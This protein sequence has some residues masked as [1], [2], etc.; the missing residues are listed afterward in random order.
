M[1][2]PVIVWSSS[3]SCQLD[4]VHVPECL[5]IYFLRYFKFTAMSTY[6][7]EGGGG[8]GGLMSFFKG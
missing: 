7:F 8:G 5:Y 1:Y 6:I 4:K 2:I 3:C